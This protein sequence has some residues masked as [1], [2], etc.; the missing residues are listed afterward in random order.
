MADAGHDVAVGTTRM[1]QAA[2]EA[3]GLRWVRA[4]IEHDDPEI[5]PIMAQVRAL[6]G[7]EQSRFFIG[8]ISGDLRPR[9]MVPELLALAKSWRPDVF[10]RDSNELGAMIASELLD[11]P[12][13]TVVVNAT[14][15]LRHQMSALYAPIQQVRSLFGLPERSTPVLMDQYL[16]L[17]PFPA[18]LNA[19]GDPIPV[20]A[21]H[22]HGLPR[23][24]SLLSCRTGWIRSAPAR[25]YT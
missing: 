23:M 25:S 12:H 4:G 16:T 3:I 22:F 14:G 21:H 7:R 5:A 8:R 18:S 19:V 24:P 10:V 15:A 13:A 20:T 1:L 11:V 9:R 6:R 17:I 2:V